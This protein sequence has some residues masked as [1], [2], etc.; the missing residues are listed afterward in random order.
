MR[1]TSIMSMPME[2]ITEATEL[3]DA[4]FYWREL[5]GV[6]ALVCAPLEQDGF[7]NGFSTRA[8][9]VSPM[10]RDALNLAGSNE[11]SAENILENRRRFLK[12]F[13]G[14]WSLAGCWQLHR[15]DI[16]VVNDEGQARSRPY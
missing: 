16:R 8:G 4:G 1:A 2:T 6:R 5:D 3:E 9:G 15:A 12:L 10:P 14:E 11:D 7:T 13:R